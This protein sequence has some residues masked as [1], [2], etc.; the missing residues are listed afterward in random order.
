MKEGIKVEVTKC[1]G[2][3]YTFY[4]NPSNRQVRDKKLKMCNACKKPADVEVLVFVKEKTLS[5]LGKFLG[6]KANQR[7]IPDMVVAEFITKA[8]LKGKLNEEQLS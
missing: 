8:L 5:V 4:L 6:K 7:K 2:S 3:P 1:C